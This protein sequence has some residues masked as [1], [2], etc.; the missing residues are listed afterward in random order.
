MHRLEMDQSEAE[1]FMI[2]PKLEKMCDV[3]G[4]IAVPYLFEDGLVQGMI[5]VYLGWG[6]VSEVS[7][8][9]SHH[10]TLTLFLHIILC[11]L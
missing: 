6:W 3:N 7:A 9:E 10:H 11:S 8:T 1:S 2:Q 4:T 5:L